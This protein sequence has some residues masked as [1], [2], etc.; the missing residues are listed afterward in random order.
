VG[1]LSPDDGRVRWAD[2]E[3]GDE[4]TYLDINALAAAANSSF[5]AAAYVTLSPDHAYVAY[6]ADAVGAESY[7]L[8]FRRIATGVELASDTVAAMR[9]SFA[10]GADTT[11]FYY[12]TQSAT[13]RPENVWRRTFVPRLEGGPAAGS[14]VANDT[15]LWEDPDEGFWLSLSRSRSDRMLMFG[16]TTSDTA[17]W[18]VLDVVADAAAV[19]GGVPPPTPTLVEA[20]GASL[21]FVEHLDG[22]TLVIKTNAVDADNFK[23]VTAPL[24]SPAAAGWV[25][26]LPYNA[27]VM[28]NQGT[29]FATFAVLS[30]RVGGY[31][32]LVTIDIV[33]CGSGASPI[34]NASTAE[35]LPLA[36]A[37]VTLSDVHGPYDGRAFTFY[38]TSPK[39]PMQT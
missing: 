26:M 5:Y 8:P 20:R 12:T 7:E 10:W 22:D 32:R 15:L 28:V 13:N 29:P 14:D 1:S 19:K 34:L 11:T 36:E 3:L 33:A 18:Y 39:T 31:T 25:D 24:A 30:V 35:V 27:S 2:E 4:E 9:G 21:Y 23:V 16:S 6:A 17:E 38:Y 37:A